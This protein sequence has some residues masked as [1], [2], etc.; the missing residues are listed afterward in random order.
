MGVV[1]VGGGGEGKEAKM[2]VG[3]R[4]SCGNGSSNPG[5]SDEA[6]VLRSI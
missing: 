6:R 1:V 4:C 5:R 3:G 2:R